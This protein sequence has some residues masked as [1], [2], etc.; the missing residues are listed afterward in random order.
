MCDN[1]LGLD[2]SSQTV[3]AALRPASGKLRQ[4]S[5]ANSAAGCQQLLAWLGVPAT[6]VHACLEA[7]G[8]YEFDWACLLYR[9]GVTVSL[10]NPLRTKAFAQAQLRRAKTDP[11][12]AGDIAA[13][14]GALRPAPWSP[15]AP[16]LLELRGLVRRVQDLKAMAAQEKCRLA[17]PGAAGVSGSLV[18]HLAQLQGEI[19]L[20]QG[21]I[22]AL[23]RQHRQLARQ[24]ELLDSI[25]G[26][27]ETTAVILLA[28]CA[29]AR[30]C[31]RARQLG[32]LCR[33]YPPDPPV[34]QVAR[35]KP[36]LQARQ[37][38]SA[39]GALVAGNL[40]DVS[41]PAADGAG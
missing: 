15:P 18:R 5:F 9:A 34:R 4:R 26:V 36:H 11:V 35:Q 29:T 33:A 24:R 40:G 7:T 37:Q 1:F 22:R 8:G 3:A 25:P 19:A 20:L 30:H 32:G 21:E 41:Q 6:R 12:D 16:E 17:A 23:F 10:V 14:C 39:G 28:E 27:G 31:Q 13:F 38:Q 2:V